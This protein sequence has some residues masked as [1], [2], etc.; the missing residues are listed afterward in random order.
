MERRSRRGAF[1][2]RGGRYLGLNSWIGL[3]DSKQTAVFVFVNRDGS[4]P[5]IEDPSDVLRTDLGEPL[6]E[7]F[8]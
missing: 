8:P 6:L 4:D 5:A 1:D 3:A 2:A 7:Q